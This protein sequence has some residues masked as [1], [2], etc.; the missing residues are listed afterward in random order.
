MPTC[1]PYPSRR[2]GRQAAARRGEWGGGGP[3]SGAPCLQAT[4]GQGGGRPAGGRGRSAGR[5]AG[6]SCGEA[7]AAS[8]QLGPAP[9]PPQ[10]PP[11]PASPYVTGGSWRPARSSLGTAP[12][13]QPAAPPPPARR[14]PSPEQRAEGERQ[15]PQS[16]L[17]RRRAAA[18]PQR[19]PTAAGGTA[20]PA[21]GAS[22]RGRWRG[23]GPR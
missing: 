5:A 23:I 1:E 9:R 11:G 18:A 22:L 13:Y 19:P 3:L 21:R 20:T 10:R 17:A 6:P 4:V 15:R 16:S 12:R 2:E 8:P 14:R 7:A